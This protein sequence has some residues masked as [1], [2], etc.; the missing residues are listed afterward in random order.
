MSCKAWG[1]RI[2]EADR[3][4][5]GGGACHLTGSP[6]PSKV[7]LPLHPLRGVWFDQGSNK[8]VPERNRARN[9]RWGLK[10]L[11]A[12]GDFLNGSSPG[13]IVVTRRD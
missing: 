7:S 8:P 4:E 2:T 3:D 11:T 1:A 9:P 12:P 10:Y 6:V 5:P 13:G